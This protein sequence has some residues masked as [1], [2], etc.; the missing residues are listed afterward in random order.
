M[1]SSNNEGFDSGPEPSTQISNT[2]RRQYLITYSRANM[3]KFPT[4]ESF[5]KAVVDSFSTSGK[6]VIN[7]WACCLEEHENTSGQ[8]YHM[9]VKLSGPKRWNK[10]YFIS[11]SF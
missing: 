4:R 9:C 11:L 5:A 3:N 6:I 2:T 7:H 1:N 8:Y 10:I